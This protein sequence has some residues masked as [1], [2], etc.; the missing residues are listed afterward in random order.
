MIENKNYIFTLKFELETLET[1]VI[2]LLQYNYK[3][4]YCMNIACTNIRQGF[5][6]KNQLLSTIAKYS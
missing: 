2:M 4:E 3:L 1:R 5:N 6:R